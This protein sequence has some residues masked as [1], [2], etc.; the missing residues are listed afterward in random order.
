MKQL[1]RKKCRS[2]G[3]FL[4]TKHA[5]LNISVSLLTLLYNFF[6]YILIIIIVSFQ[7]LEKEIYINTEF[8]CDETDDDS[9]CLKKVKDSIIKNKEIIRSRFLF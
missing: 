2:C 8:D 1:I 3:K 6:L 5:V 9:K 7:K 4:N